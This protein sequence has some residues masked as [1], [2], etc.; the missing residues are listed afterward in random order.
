MT[1]LITR[2][3]VAVLTLSAPP[4]NAINEELLSDLERASAQLAGESD[5]TAVLVRSA[6]RFF[7][8]GVDISMIDRLAATSGSVDALL[9]FNRRLQSFYTAWERL[10]LITVAALEGT[11]AGGGLEF[12]LACDLRVAADDAQLGL[13]EAKIG[14]VPG[15]GGTQ[16]L[17]RLV[18]L[19]VATR[20]IVTGEL[21]C[22]SEAAQLGVVQTA[23]RR[24]E[25]ERTALDLVRRCAALPRATIVGLK[26]CLALA[27]SAAGYEA[28]LTHTRR[29]MESTDSRRLIGEFL[30]RHPRQTAAS[31]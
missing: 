10:G 15:G 19:S 18:G 30:H 20:L 13:P 12:A 25:V 24:S 3:N 28:E 21:I 4:V 6:Q 17:T 27:P 1:S 14:L 31:E 8:P 11:A 5:V 16:R 9:T 2:G 26:E 22:G 7:S 29:I 23:V